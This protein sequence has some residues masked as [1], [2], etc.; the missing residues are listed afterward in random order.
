MIFGFL[1]IFW[2]KYPIDDGDSQDNNRY[3]LFG[4]ANNE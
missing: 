2:D 4:I 1:P 3:R